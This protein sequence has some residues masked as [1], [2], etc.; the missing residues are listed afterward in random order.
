MAS[1]SFSFVL[2]S[3]IL[4][5]LAAPVPVSVLQTTV[6]SG[7]VTLGEVTT[8]SQGGTFVDFKVAPVVVPSSD[9]TVLADADTSASPQ[10]LDSRVFKPEAFLPVHDSTHFKRGGII[11]NFVGSI[12]GG[13]GCSDG[14]GN[15]F[16]AKV[17]A[18]DKPKAPPPNG[19][20]GPADLA[21][22]QAAKG[23][24][25]Q[26]G[27]NPAQGGSSKANKAGSSKAHPGRE[28]SSGTR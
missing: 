23:A 26:T 14:K 17:P 7:P 25:A 19:A 6:A 2:F 13:H 18:N 4:S 11:P 28:E 20:P 1:L 15:C 10:S 16:E 9:E 24:P 3:L 27:A 21:A 5:A 12:F 8:P 22:P